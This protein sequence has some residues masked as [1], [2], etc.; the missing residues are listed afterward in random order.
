MT[1][2]FNLFRQWIEPIGILCWVPLILAGSGAIAPIPPAHAQ[3]LPTPRIFGEELPPPSPS[4]S[5]PAVFNPPNTPTPSANLYRVDVLGDSP[6][7]LSQVQQIEPEAFIRW[8]EGMIQAGVFADQQNAQSRVRALETQGIRSR[9]TKI[10]VSAGFDSAASVEPGRLSTVTG[11][12]VIVPGN[13]QNLPEIATQIV[14][15]GI[16][17]NA[18][19]Q[20]DFPRGPH[21]AVGP[22][23]ERETAER[24]SSYLRSDG[25]DARVYYGR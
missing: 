5:S 8:G 14:R 24:W 22:F 12:F 3:R 9:V 7:L 23:D 20:R 25:L 18:V 15:L 16:G 13:P 1:R 4:P 10:A 2:F 11:Y 19:N 17:R 6:F 21:V